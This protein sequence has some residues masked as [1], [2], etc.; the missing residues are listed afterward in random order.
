MNAEQKQLVLDSIR[1]KPVNRIP[2]FYRADEFVNRKMINHFNIGGRDWNEAILRNLGADF[3]SGGPSLNDFYCYLPRYIGPDFACDHD[4]LFFFS[5]GIK[6]KCV[7]DEKGRFLEYDFFQNPPLGKAE[8]IA[9]V[10]AHHW[11]EPGWFDFTRYKTL[12]SRRAPEWYPTDGQAGDDYVSVDEVRK[13]DDQFTSTYFQ[14]TIFVVSSFMRGMER[15]LLDMAAEPKLAH[16]VV[17]RVGEACVAMNRANLAAIGDRIELFGMWDDFAM[18]D[19]MLM[20]PDTWREYFK[21]WYARLIAEA[22]RYGLMVYFHCCGNC[23]EVIG[24]LIDIGIDILDP[25]QTSARRM[26]WP[27]LKREFGRD[28]CFHGGLD[29]QKLL[30]LGT[31]A[32]VRAEVRRVKDLFGGDGGILLGPSH[33]LTRDTPTE[34]VLAIFED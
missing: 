16:A 1:R 6:S 15:L 3:F 28:V 24:D 19:N 2:M 11:P 7:Y 12:C 20:P 22:K 27:D 33:L 29:V 18:Q 17:D 10:A 32:D 8:S 26:N 30:P 14:N 34:N 5:F 31:P 23:F 25:I 21:P 9:E 4:D 13:R